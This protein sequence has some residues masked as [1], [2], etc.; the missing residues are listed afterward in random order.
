MGP[1]SC[2]GACKFTGGDETQEFVYKALLRLN[3]SNRT[4]HIILCH[5]YVQDS[6]WTH[7]LRGSL[8]PTTFYSTSS[9]SVMVLHDKLVGGLL[10]RLTIPCWPCISGNGS[11]WSGSIHWTCIWH[12][13]P[14]S[15]APYSASASNFG[16]KSQATQ[17]G[18]PPGGASIPKP[19]LHDSFGT[20]PNNRRSTGVDP[21]M[22]RNDANNNSRSGMVWKTPSKNPFMTDCNLT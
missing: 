4:F 10:R 5:R 21:G 6:V 18:S 16:A 22:A 15:A 2:K 9:Q 11:E 12:D 17:E 14:Q 19:I 13:G 3:L 8:K 20:V 7:C 1:L